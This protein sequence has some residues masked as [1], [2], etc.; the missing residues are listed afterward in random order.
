M[1]TWGSVNVFTGPQVLSNSTRRHKFFYRSQCVTNARGPA[2]ARPAAAA[3]EGGLFNGTNGFGSIRRPLSRLMASHS[4]H[5]AA[6]CFSGGPGEAEQKRQTVGSL[7]WAHAE[8]LVKVGT[9]A[10]LLVELRG[11]GQIGAGFKV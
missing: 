9:D 11:L 6:A 4:L 8:D 3:A 2:A 1:A 5:G 7:T 10:H